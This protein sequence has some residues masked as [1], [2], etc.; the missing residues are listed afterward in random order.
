M[1]MKIHGGNILKDPLKRF[2]EERR[3]NSSEKALKMDQCAV[4]SQN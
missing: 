2:N 1:N 3:K 4:F